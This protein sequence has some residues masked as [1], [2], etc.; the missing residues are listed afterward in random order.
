LTARGGLGYRGVMATKDQVRSPGRMARD[1]FEAI[2]DRR[3]IDAV[4]PMWN[5]DS[6]DHFLALGIDARGPDQLVAF[7]REA[8]AAFPD[9]EMTIEHVV[10]DDRHAVVQWSLKGT[11][12]GGPFQGVEPTG[13]PIAL[14]GCD[15]FSFTDDGKLDSNTIYYDGAEF[16]RQIGMLPR[17]GSA[18][19]RALL[20]AF[21]AKARLQRRLRDR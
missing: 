2:F 3:D 5:E 21:N 20:E 13:K 8:L 18:A 11:F 16:A 6:V 19:D 12:D 7:F 14:R 4:R 9:L 15:V 1:A 10:E 17:R